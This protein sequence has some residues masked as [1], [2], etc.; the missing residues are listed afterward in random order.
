MTAVDLARMQSAFTV[1]FHIL[2][3][4]FS[5]GLAWFVALLSVLSWATGKLVYRD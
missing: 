2:W 4:T 5:I 3:P 1:G